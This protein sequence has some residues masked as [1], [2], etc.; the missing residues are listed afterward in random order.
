MVS[1]RLRSL[2]ELARMG[3]LQRRWLHSR[4]VTAAVS[5]VAV[6]AALSS[7]SCGIFDT[8]TS[9]PPG[10]E[11]PCP[12][13]EPVNADAVISN[14]TNAVQCFSQAN[15]DEAVAADFVFIPDEEDRAFFLSQAGTDIFE[16]WGKDEEMSA[17]RK[18][19]SES[20]TLTVRMS[21]RDRTP[22]T[23]EVMIRMDYVFR[24]VIKRDGAA[25]SVAVF[26][27]LAHIHLRSGESNNWAIDEWLEFRTGQADQTW[28]F[29]KGKVTPG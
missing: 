27:G 8:R 16:N 12:R 25:D 6:V 22:G 18:I 23:N 26:K 11:T 1:P 15:Y 7:S 3:V 29:L 2:L 4:A 13:D 24:R 14:F 21:E 5:A 10:T 19:F 28:G 17:V 9:E 20:D